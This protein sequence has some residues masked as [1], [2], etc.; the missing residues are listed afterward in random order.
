[1]PAC[2]R[3]IGALACLL[4]T[5]IYAVAG[6]VPS[7]YEKL[8]W[9]TNFAKVVKMY[10]RGQT[11]RL[12]DEVVYRQLRPDRT[13]SRRNFAFREGKL[14]TVAVTLEKRYVE[15]KGIEHVLQDQ[16]SRFGEGNMDRSRAPDMINYIW[17]GGGSRITFAYAPKHPDMTV[18]MYEQK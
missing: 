1:M 2:Y 8:A 11:V 10:P 6:T 7:G 14:H 3:V 5:A 4:F 9:N 18:I 13:I 16:I 12:G 15:K 17:E